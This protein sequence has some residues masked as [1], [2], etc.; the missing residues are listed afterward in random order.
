MR[1]KDRE[2]TGIENILKILEKC[3]VLRLG[4]CA[5]NIPYVVPMNF[6]YE[7]NDNDIFIYL[8]CAKE[9]KKLDLI[10]TNNNVCF[11][12]DCSHKIIKGATACNWTSKYESV[13]GNGEIFRLNGESEKI[14]A[15]DLLMKRYGF[16]GK[17]T[18]PERVLASV[19][20]L[21]IKVTSISGKANV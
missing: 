13:I 17:P 21:K 2:V 19:E 16:E 10:A 6:A 11:E 15:M 4:L 14:E 9:G 8:H 1:R 3:E 7:A 5:D 12:A 18:Y 20:V